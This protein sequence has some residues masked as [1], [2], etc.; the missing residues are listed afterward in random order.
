MTVLTPAD[1]RTPADVATWLATLGIHLPLRVSDRGDDA[2]VIYDA[3]GR[4]VIVADN[5]G[6]RPDDEA[7]AI[8]EIVVAAIHHAA[9]YIPI[10]PDTPEAPH[11]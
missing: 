1:I 2:G 10:G 11:A 3:G 8:A 6:E 7:S 5:L 9:G 4:E